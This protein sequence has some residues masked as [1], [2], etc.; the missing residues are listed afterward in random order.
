MN[1]ASTVDMRK[2][3]DMAYA[4]KDA[5]ILFVPMPVADDTEQAVRFAEAEARLEQ[6]AQEAEAREGSQ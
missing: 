4:L 2:A 6:M 3:M 5:G 1:R